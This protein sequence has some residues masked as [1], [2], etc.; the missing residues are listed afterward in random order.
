MVKQDHKFENCLPKSLSIKLE[1]KV[2]CSVE[3]REPVEL[4]AKGRKGH[5]N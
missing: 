3:E 5:E 2:R 1:K 4:K